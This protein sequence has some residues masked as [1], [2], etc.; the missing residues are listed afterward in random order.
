MQRGLFFHLGGESMVP[1]DFVLFLLLG[2]AVITDLKSRKIPNWLILTGLIASF[3]YHAYTG[4]T[5]GILFALKGFAVGMVLLIIPF[6]MGGMGA[7]DVKLLGVV[8]A[9][10]GSLFVFYSFLLMAIWGGLIAGMILIKERR[11]KQMFY[12]IGNSFLTANFGFLRVVDNFDHKEL[13]YY[14]PYAL[15]IALGVISCFIKGWCC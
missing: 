3:G 1:E 6:I 14:F 4:G 2:I 12:K 10:K 7:G 11:L 15:A 8:G 9:F 5:D 13:N